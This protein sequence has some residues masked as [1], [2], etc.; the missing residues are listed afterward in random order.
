M[1]VLVD[2]VDSIGTSIRFIFLL[3]FLAIFGFGILMTA[4]ASYVAPKVAEEVAD[5]A[6][7]YAEREFQRKRD[8]ELGK[9]GWGSGSNSTASR[10]SARGT[11]Q[12][13]FGEDNGGWADERRDRY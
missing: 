1:R 2:L 11:A 8:K 7:R 3:F 4:G 5:R 10:K 6:D 13:E 12:G 9:S